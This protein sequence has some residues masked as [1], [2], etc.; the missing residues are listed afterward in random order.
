MLCLGASATTSSVCKHLRDEGWNVHRA[1]DFRAAHRLAAEHRFAVGLLVWPDVDDAMS[2]EI[3]AFLRDHA[4][5]EWVGCFSAASI[6][7]AAC[8]DLILS[9]LFDHHTL[10]LDLPRVVACLGHAQGRAALRMLPEI[11]VGIHGPETVGQSPPILELLKQ[12]RRVARTDAPVLIRGESG[13]GKE[14]IARAV[15]RASTRA[16]GPF[17]AINCGAMQPSLVQ[18]ELFGHERGAFTGAQAERRGLFETAEGG[19]VFLDEIGDL[20]LDQQVN[21]L[22]FLEEGTITRVG[23]SRS[24]RL[25]VRVIAATHVDL[26]AA[27]ADGQFRQDLFYRLNVLP[28]Q[29]PPLREHRD[30]IKLL[31]HHFFRKFSAEKNPKVKGFSSRALQAMES[32]DWPGN[33]RELINRVRYAMIMTDARLIGPDDLSLEMPADAAPPNALGDARLQAERAAIFTSLEQTGRNVAGSAR[34]L[35][36]SRMT[37]YRLMVKHGLH[38]AH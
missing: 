23:S 1:V 9:H 25:D 35:G 17:V 14:V 29:V 30:D 31:A 4:G 10:P 19:T 36:V 2:R 3:D 34:Q 28:L 7:G 6:T 11:S 32:H 16:T 20:P 22:R 33:V 8:R 27:V 18:S 21:L 24:I 5:V 13:S 12:A 37:L 38:V 15:Q 26:E